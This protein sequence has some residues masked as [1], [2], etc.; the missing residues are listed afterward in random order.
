MTR[1]FEITLF[2][3]AVA[4]LLF[5]VETRAAN[6]DQTVQELS[7]D[8]RHMTGRVVPSGID[9]VWV[10]DLEVFEQCRCRA[11]ALFVEGGIRLTQDVNL[12]TNEGRA[13][14][15]HELVH[16]AQ[17]AAHGV[18]M[19]CADWLARENEAVTLERRWRVDHSARLPPIPQYQCKEKS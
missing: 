12:D 16:G 17:W 13:I 18:A 5:V 2:I 3:L 14:L 6:V 11:H 4:L 8:Y 19:G 7:A 9:V 15:F 10:S 1:L